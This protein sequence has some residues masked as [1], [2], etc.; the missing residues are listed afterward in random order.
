MRLFQPTRWSK[1]ETCPVL[2]QGFLPVWAIHL[3]DIDLVYLYMHLYV[4]DF[5]GQS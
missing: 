2:S 3:D 1:T 5:L 4:I